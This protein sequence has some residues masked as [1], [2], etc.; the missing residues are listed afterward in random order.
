MAQALSTQVLFCRLPA[1]HTHAFS[2]I[3][4]QDV[5]EAGFEMTEAQI[6]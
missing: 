5:L 3:T 2:Q 6:A 4:G 1:A